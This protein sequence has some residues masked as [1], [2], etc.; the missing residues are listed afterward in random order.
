MSLGYPGTPTDKLWRLYRFWVLDPEI[1]TQFRRELEGYWAIN[2]S[3][4]EATVVWDA[5]KAFTRGQYQTIIAKFRKERKAA[6][7]KAESEAG[8]QEAL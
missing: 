8:T 2:P 1:D 3:S 5:F 6:L 4:A 7:I